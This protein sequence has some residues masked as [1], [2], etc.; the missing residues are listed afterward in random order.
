MGLIRSS[1]GRISGPHEP[2]HVKFG[3]WGFFI[4][5]YWNIVMKMLKCKKENLMTSHFSTLLSCEVNK[6][7]PA[8]WLLC[9]KSFCVFYCF[10]YLIISIKNSNCPVMTLLHSHDDMEISSELIHLKFTLPLCIAYSKSS[11]GGVWNSNEKAQCYCCVVANLP[12]P[13]ARINF[14]EG[15]GTPQK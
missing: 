4:M 2:I 5:F 12:R 10:R 14:F 8:F 9:E 13:V 6:V 11:T 7:A 15:C 3:V 1:C